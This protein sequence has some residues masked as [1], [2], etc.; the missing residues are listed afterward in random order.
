MFI[1]VMNR[2]VLHL[3]INIMELRKNPKIDLEKKRGMFFSIGLF[4]SMLFV[5]SAFQWTT[6]VPPV[7][8]WE[9]EELDEFMPVMDPMVTRMDPPPKPR[10]IKPIALGGKIIVT[11]EVIDLLIVDEP[12]ED[13]LDIRDYQLPPEPIIEGPF[14]VVEKMPEPIGG[15]SSFMK[16][17]GKNIKYPRRAKTMGVEGKVYAQFIVDT[18]GSLTDLKVI[19]GIGAGC[20]QEALRVIALAPN[21]NPGKQRGRAVR[22]RMIVPVYFR[23]R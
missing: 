1:T 17:L 15:M 4:L 19:K 8:Y 18:D 3:N 23:L 9:P 10:V 11:E 22:V 21:W 12:V 2:H 7:V 14:V 13:P 6:A 16:F 5:F 20:D